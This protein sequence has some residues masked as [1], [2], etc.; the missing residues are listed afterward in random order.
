MNRIL[1]RR[2]AAVI[3]FTLLLFT[4]GCK[5]YMDVQPITE[6]GVQEAFASVN[7]TFNSLLGVYDELQ[8]DNGYGIRISL[9]YPFDSD[10]GMVSGDIDN[11]RRG[12][13]RY[14]LLLSNS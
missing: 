3:T 11:G 4:A 13:G 7:A 6:F 9:Y 12:V 8:G 14:Q 5:K 1:F 10:E 2:S